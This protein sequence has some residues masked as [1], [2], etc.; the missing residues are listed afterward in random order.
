[1]NG[2]VMQAGGCW[3]SFDFEWNRFEQRQTSYDF[4]FKRIALAAVLRIEVREKEQTRQKGKVME[5]FAVFQSRDVYF[6]DWGMSGENGGEW[7]HYR[8][9]LK[10][11]FEAFPNG[12][13][14]LYE[15]E[16]SRRTPGASLV[17]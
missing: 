5:M 11:D 8:Y 15:K 14:L 3:K 17:V 16:E 12:L 6:F 9:L 4:L 13:N 7:F 10:M 1:M 2:Q